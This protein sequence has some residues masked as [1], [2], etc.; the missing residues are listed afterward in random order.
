MNSPRDPGSTWAFNGG[1]GLV[2]TNGPVTFGM[3]VIYE[4]VWSHTWAT[5][6]GCPTDTQCVDSLAP[7]LQS[8]DNHFRFS[9]SRM[10][11]GVARDG[12]PVG[13]QLGMDV[14]SVSYVLRQE[15]LIQGNSRRQHESWMEWTPTWGLSLR[16]PELTVRYAG[17]LTTGTGQPG[18][19]WGGG[20]VAGSTAMGFSDV[21]IAPS[22]P[23]T[24]QNASVI[25]HQISV[26]L[27]IR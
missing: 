27:P 25:R 24:L 12:Q 19:A 16:F 8:F 14:Y 4:P 20:F 11:M 13:F 2:R 17:R 5:V 9:N 7:P 23:M 21:V 1:V 22:D 10:R 18:V 15:E 6:G 3:D 26:T